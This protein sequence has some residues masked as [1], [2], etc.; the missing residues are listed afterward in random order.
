MKKSTYKRIIAYF[1][2]SALLGC[3]EDFLDK[4]PQTSKSLE[5][6]SSETEIRAYLNQFYSD[7]SGD[8][9][10]N[11]DAGTDNQGIDPIGFVNDNYIV[12]SAD[13]N[14]SEPYANIR[15]VNILL[16]NNDV[17][18][19]VS[20]HLIGE[21]YFWR[22]WQ[23]FNLLKRFGGVPLIK[24]VVPTNDD[25]MLNT[26]RSSR[27]ETADFIL[28]DLDQAIEMMNA[29]DDD[30]GNQG[31]NKDVALAFKTR[32]ALYEGTWEKYHAGTE[33]GIPGSNGSKYL[34]AAVEAA[35]T[36]M[37][38]GRYGI[39]KRAGQ[40]YTDLFIQEDLSSN[41]EVIWWKE[42][43]LT[44]RFVTR[45]MTIWG[46]YLTKNFVDAYLENDGSPVAVN[47]EDSPSS[48]TSYYWVTESDMYE[49]RDP[50]LV[51][52]IL[53][54][55]DVVNDTEKRDLPGNQ[56]FT[57]T[58][59]K[60]YVAD[61][62][63]RYGDD[64]SNSGE[65][66]FRYAEVLLNYLEAKAELE[67][68]GE[69]A[70]Q[71]NDEDINATVALLRDRV[72]WNSWNS[73]SALAEFEKGGAENVPLLQYQRNALTGVKADLIHA[74][75]RER[76]VELICEGFRWDDLMRW[77]MGDYL[78]NYVNR[79]NTKSVMYEINSEEA[80]KPV[81]YYDEDEF[82]F[83]VMWEGVDGLNFV[84]N[85]SYLYPVPFR[86]IQLAGYEQNPGWE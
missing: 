74:I 79:G 17:P 53:L 82:S 13:G 68:L 80:Q 61:P 27:S 33:F 3:S 20:R 51:Q 86:Q 1:C 31:V 18:E 71:V 54:A 60:Y 40:A 25:E 29:R 76:R 2:L 47:S 21:A 12:P 77:R 14:W 50:R 69:A 42:Y 8:I 63:R 57:L 72:E 15:T 73:G 55:G 7:D 24:D 44:D 22:A 64:S 5:S 43:N 30:R 65:I 85:K 52:T 37:N 84:E 6:F 35:Q 34:I 46:G 36:L 16:A 59:R 39:W 78:R 41:R 83:D 48:G 9:I 38:S 19:E 23:Y 62:E 11:K 56:S 49:N 75:R 81:Y 10:M 58:M 26:P 4:E 28:E 32:V 67:E 66:I 70:Y 45:M